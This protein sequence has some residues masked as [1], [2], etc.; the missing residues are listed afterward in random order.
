MQ[1]GPSFN[2]ISTCTVELT[3]VW[4][5]SL[6]LKSG[7]HGPFLTANPM[8]F[9]DPIQISRTLNFLLTDVDPWV[10]LVDAATVRCGG[11]LERS[12][13]VLR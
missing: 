3:P 8:L 11:Q 7:T 12:L 9:E 5:A 10:T 13:Q 6:G 4:L 2:S 1:A